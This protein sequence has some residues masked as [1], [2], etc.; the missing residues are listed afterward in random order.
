LAI[1][2]NAGRGLPV[3]TEFGFREI[4]GLENELEKPEYQKATIFVA[5]E[6]SLL[7]EFVKDMVKT[8][9]GYP[10]QVPAWPGKDY[11]TVFLVKINRSEGH[12]TVAFTVDHEGLD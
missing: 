3:N 7:D 10:A 8:H 9:G 11:D 4:K 6:H 12:E 2:A 1:K 5:W